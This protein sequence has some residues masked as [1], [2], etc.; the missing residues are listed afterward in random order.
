MN[1]ACPSCGAVYAVTAKD[2]GRKIKCKKCGSALRVDDSGLMMDGP[3]APPPP[4]APV[5]EVANE[6]DTGDE[7]LV[8]VKKKGKKTADRDDDQGRERYRGP[9]GPGLV[10]KL[11]GIPTILLGVG[12]LFVLWFTFMTPIGYASIERAQ[13]TIDKLKLEKMSE[14]KEPKLTDERRGKINEEYEKKIA[15]AGEDAASA[16]I[17]NT[18]SRRFEKYGQLFGFILVAAGCIALLRTQQTPVMQYVA[19]FILASMMFVVFV[20]AS[21]CPGGPSPRNLMGKD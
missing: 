19:G 8:S 3:T 13:A 11:G 12:V 15:E 5:A 6:F 1:N 4:P 17:D 18:R 20:Q 2:V 21:G 16:V 9:S 14:L 7:G 10:E